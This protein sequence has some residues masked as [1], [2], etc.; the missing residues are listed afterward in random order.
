LTRSV[1]CSTAC[2]RRLRTNQS[3]ESARA[4]RAQLRGRLTL[5]HTGFTG[6]GGFILS[7]LMMGPGWRKML[8]V[9]IP[10]VL[11]DIDEE[12][13]LRSGSSLKPKY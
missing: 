7:K 10:A 6:I 12:G 1:V 2:P 5:E 9:L 4:E 11:D 3:A 13:K 8:G